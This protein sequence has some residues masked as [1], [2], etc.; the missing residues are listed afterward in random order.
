MI[1]PASNP[2]PCGAA[3]QGASRLEQRGAWPFFHMRSAGYSAARMPA[4]RPHRHRHDRSLTDERRGGEHRPVR[5]RRPALRHRARGA[6]RRV[7]HA[8]SGQLLFP[9]RGERRGQD[10]AAQAAVPRPAPLARDD[11]HVRDRRDH[12]AARAPARASAGGIGVV[13]QDFRLVP[14]LSAFDNVALPLRVVGRA[15]ERDLR[16]PV[17]DMLEWVGLG[18]SQPMRARRRCRAASSSAWRSPAR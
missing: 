12:P 14:H 2:R 9:H 5:Q 11:P 10:L 17:A 4:S 1:I 6:E 15:G 18:R 7:V 13:F 16:K 3:Q 8:L